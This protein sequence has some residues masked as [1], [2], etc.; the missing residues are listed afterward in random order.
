MVHFP[1]STS[2]Y[3]PSICLESKTRHVRDQRELLTVNKSSTGFHFA[4]AQFLFEEQIH[5][6]MWF[7]K[8]DSTK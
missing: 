8:K 1:T 6:S 2:Y 5:G 4:L 7:Y 3:N